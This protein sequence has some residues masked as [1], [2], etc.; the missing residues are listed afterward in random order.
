MKRKISSICIVVLIVSIFMTCLAPAFASDEITPRYTAI[1]QISSSLSISSLGGASCAGNVVLD[2]GYTADLVVEL[3]QDGTTIK[4]WTASGSGSFS[5]GGLY[6]VMS[7]HDYIVRT[8]A[9]VYNSNGKL[10]EIVAKNS[11]GSTY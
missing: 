2:D 8:T 9:T 4:T 6:Y 7:G 1:S 11:L 3:R 10:V 5:A